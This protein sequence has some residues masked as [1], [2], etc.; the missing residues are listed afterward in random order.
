M[1]AIYLN[2]NMCIHIYTYPS[3]FCLVESVGTV[4]GDVAVDWGIKG[5]WLVFLVHVFVG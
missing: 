2:V 3:I 5:R 1:L 4:V